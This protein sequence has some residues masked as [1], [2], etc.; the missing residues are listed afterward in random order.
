MTS[1]Y[2]SSKVPADGGGSGLSE[3][4]PFGSLECVRDILLG[5]GDQVLLER[6]SVFQD[7]ALHLKEGSCGS[8]ERPILIAAYGNGPAPV[9]NANGMGQWLQDYNTT[10][11]GGHRYRAVISTA[12]LLKD[13][14]YIEVEG[15]EITN[16]RELGN[17]DGLA[18]NDR[19]AMNRTGVA[20]IAQDAGTLHHI[21]LA[22]L[23]IH[24]VTGNV[25]DKHLANGGIYCIAH[26]PKDPSRR[27]TDIARFDDMRIVGNRLDTVGRW[28]IA[29]GYTAYLNELDAD[30]Y[31]DGTIADEAIARWGH[32]GVLVEN[33]YVKDAGGDAIT[34]MYCDRPLVQYNVAQGAARQVN[35]VDYSATDF[36]K[37]AAGIWPWRC[38][39]AVFQYNEVFGM[40]GGAHGNDDGQAWDADYGDGTLYQYNYSH[41]N[42][43][44]TVMFCMSKS[45]NN[46]FRYN[47]A[48]GDLKGA[49]DIPDNPDAHIYHNTFVIPE[50][51]TIVRDN[52]VGGHALV[53]NNIFINAGREPVPGNW[54]Q[55]GSPVTYANNLYCNF[56]D[57]P[58][59]PAG[60]AVP[61]GM[62]ALRGPGSAPTA[63][64]PDGMIRVHDDPDATT[65]FDGYRPVAQGPAFGMAK[66]IEDRNGFAQEK[67]FL[68]NDVARGDD[69]GGDA[70]G[71]IVRP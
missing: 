5:P 20:V 67:D 54:T 46:T 2:I 45:V 71:A 18:Y 26:Y 35:D 22:G 41:G 48:Q 24:D 42:T 7:Q 55:G 38:K 12:V 53:E 68:G 23:N 10:E 65:V 6:G 37:V 62:D 28:G 19:D 25:Y 11:I 58:D 1:Y 66:P 14:Q 63:P 56:A 29:V 43:G 52:H 40:R 4:D 64:D 59:D 17:P 36:G 16:S 47:I 61:D 50:G 51:G 27:E 15:L 30:D 8:E 3:N 13:V 49:I 33:N 21:V 9:I 57:M 60:R 69:A 34:V 44:G 39:N 32:T 70:V 31:G